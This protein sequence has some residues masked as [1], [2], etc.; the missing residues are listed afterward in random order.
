MY[1]VALPKTIFLGAH[2]YHEFLYF[3]LLFFNE[4]LEAHLTSIVHKY[5]ICVIQN[6]VFAQTPGVLNFCE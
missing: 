3:F 1:K 6:N 2:M 4:I 5:D